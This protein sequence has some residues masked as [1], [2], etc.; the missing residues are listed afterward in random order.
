DRD[1]SLLR[2][3]AGRVPGGRGDRS[4]ARRAPARHAAP[5][6]L[7]DP[8]LLERRHGALFLLPLRRTLAAARA[9][10]RARPPPSRALPRDALGF[11]VDDPLVRAPGLPRLRRDA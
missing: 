1:P 8:P 3:R 4:G 9:A 7:L 11:L 5:D 2:A 6:V 10:D